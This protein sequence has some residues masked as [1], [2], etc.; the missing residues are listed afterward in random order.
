MVLVST[1]CFDD[2]ILAEIVISGSQ[3]MTKFDQIFD[4]LTDLI[5]L[6]LLFSSMVLFQDNH[7]LFEAR[8]VWWVVGWW[9]FEVNDFHDFWSQI[10]VV[11]LV[12]PK[13]E[14]ERKA[15]GFAAWDFYALILKSEK[16]VFEQKFAF[17]LVVFFVHM[18]Q[19]HFDFYCFFQFLWIG[20][21]FRN[22]FPNQFMVHFRTSFLL[23]S[24]LHFSL[25]FF[26]SR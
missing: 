2:I 25:V 26:C 24:N 4:V 5:F 8:F 10:R 1:S 20:F 11:F 3:F 13:Q 14:L 15:S 7:K 21:L 12:T 22:G 16:T 18:L 6:L 23:E 9:I 17:S 19:F